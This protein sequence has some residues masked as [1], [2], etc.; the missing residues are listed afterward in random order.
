VA[1]GT[2][3]RKRRPPANARVAPATAR[4]AKRP[5]RPAWEEQLFFGRLR[6][7]AKWM[8]VLLAAVFALSFVILGVGSGST[9]ISDILQ[10]FFNGSSASGPSLSS[11][12]KKTQEQPKNAAAW[13]A[14]ANKLQQKGQPDDAASAL[15]TYTK[16]K[17]K[18]QNALLQLAGIYLQRAQAWETLYSEAAQLTQALAPGSTLQPSSSSKLGQALGSLTDPIANAVSSQTSSQ[19]TN[20][21]EQVLN[22]LSQREDAYKKLAKLTPSDATNQ[23]S[24][25]QAAEDAQDAKTAITA[26]KAFL[27]LAPSDSQAPAARTAIKQL[28]AQQAAQSSSSTTTGG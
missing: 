4:P 12:Q 27:K 22:Y 2:Q 13:L 5:S 10:S 8:F 19:T 6:T 1:R 28:Q 21:Y 3:H 20:D 9:G 18:D 25:A 7:H 16:L 23:Y 26:Y 17:P 14:Y 24:L 11:L 15:T